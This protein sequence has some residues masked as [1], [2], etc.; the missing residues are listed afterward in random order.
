M[1]NQET[2]RT[3]YLVQLLESALNQNDPKSWRAKQILHTIYQIKI[4]DPAPAP[5]GVFG[6]LH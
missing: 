1:G 5:G 3:P 4:H 2:P 6:R